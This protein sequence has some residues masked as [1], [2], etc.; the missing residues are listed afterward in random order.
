MHYLIGLCGA[1]LRLDG[2][3]VFLAL[4]EAEAG[5]FDDDAPELELLEHVRA[6]DLCYRLRFVRGR[7]CLTTCGGG[8]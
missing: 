4:V 6:G 3:T 8:L 7:G 1:T 5:L 2:L